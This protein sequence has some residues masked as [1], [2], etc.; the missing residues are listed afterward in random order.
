M[1]IW[2]HSLRLTTAST[3]AAIVGH[4][5]VLMGVVLIGSEPLN[6]AFIFVTTRNTKDYSSDLLLAYESIDFGG[7]LIKRV[8]QTST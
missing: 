3:N 8:N 2:L 6:T 4:S 1:V 7:C 5:V